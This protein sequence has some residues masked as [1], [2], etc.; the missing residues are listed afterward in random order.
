[1]IFTLFERRVDEDEPAPLGWRQQSA[2]TRESIRRL[3]SHAR[4]LGQRLAKV[5]RL[6]TLYFEEHQPIH[7]AQRAGCEKRGSGVAQA[8][9]VSAAGN[10]L[11][12]ASKSG[13][14]G[15]GREQLR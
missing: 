11:A 9:A 4:A 1:M 12:I 3:D 7:R 15:R 8:A 13:I 6:L 10:L 14:P 5:A 2:Q